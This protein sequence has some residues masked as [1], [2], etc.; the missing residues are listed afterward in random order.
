MAIAI[1]C[2]RWL[3]P[4]GA[5]PVGLLRVQLPAVIKR[6]F[7][8]VDECTNKIVTHQFSGHRLQ[9]ANSGPCFRRRRKSTIAALF[10]A[11]KKP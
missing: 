1:C 10:Q 3:Q 4:G 6:L 2:A 9:A 11:S 8:L 7:P 5:I